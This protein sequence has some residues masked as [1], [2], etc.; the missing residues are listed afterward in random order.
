MRMLGL[1]GGLT[2]HSTAVYYDRMNRRVAQRLGPYRSC[3]MV[4]SSID[5]GWVRAARETGDW[6]RLGAQLVEACEGLH[7]A[8]ADALV[9][10]SNTIHRFAPRIAERVDLPILHIADAVAARALE[11]GHDAIGLVGTGFTMSRSFYRTRLESHGLTVHVPDAPTI[12]ALDT[13][14]LER[15]ARGVID[16]A[17]RARFVAA[18]DSLSAAGATLHVLGCTEIGLLVSEDDVETPLV[19]SALVHADHAVDWALAAESTSSL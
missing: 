10:C 19:D 15:L 16:D 4:L 18:L 13:I 12:D 3:R 1:L 8:G 14:V 9:L 2:W 5:Y 6:K 17:D 7:A 11:D